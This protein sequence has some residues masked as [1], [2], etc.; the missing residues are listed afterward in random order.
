[1]NR[2]LGIGVEKCVLLDSKSL[3]LTKSQPTAD[4]EQW[5][6]GPH[7]QVVLEFRSTKWSFIAASPG[8]LRSIGTELWEVMQDLNAHFL[9]DDT[10]IAS[11]QDIDNGKGTID[12]NTCFSESRGTC[13]F[14]ENTCLVYFHGIKWGP[15]TEVK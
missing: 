12:V 3:L 11:R 13:L 7:D 10:V 5:R 9:L 15:S 4:L 1:M 14:A 2:L 6:A 8:A